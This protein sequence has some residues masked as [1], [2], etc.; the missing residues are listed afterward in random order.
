VLDVGAGDGALTAA[1]AS[2]GARVL[3]VELHPARVDLLRRRFAGVPNVRV[4]RADAC[5]LRLPRGPFRVV[6][7]PPFASSAALVRRL[8]SRGSGLVRADLVLPRTFARRWERAG[9]R[10]YEARVARGLPRGATAPAAP[11]DLAVLVLTRRRGR[12]T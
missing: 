12:A 5:D 6:A 11:M 4:V 2:T 8:T 9:L 7:N 1:L 10:D 3:A